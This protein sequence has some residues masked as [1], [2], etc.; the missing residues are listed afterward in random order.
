V[1]ELASPITLRS[2][3]R[4]PV[5]SRFRELCLANAALDALLMPE[6]EYRYFSFNRDW[7]AG[8][9]MASLRDGSGGHHF[10][11]FCESGTFVKGF[12]P[13]SPLSTP[14]LG[15][16]ADW[17]T[18]DVPKG[19]RAALAEPAFD[20]EALTYCFWSTAPSAPWCTGLPP[21]DSLLDI[22][23]GHLAILVDEPAVYADWASEYY[24]RS[25]SADTVR[26]FH[27]L[28]PM[29][30]QTLSRLMDVSR[31]EEFTDELIEIGY[32]VRERT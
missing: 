30:A 12:D 31:V 18:A 8:E 2:L 4:L 21:S 13:V 28:V 20:M 3:E 6:W 9:Q 10:V 26:L 23:L 24:E 22:P 14:F 1:P 17:R 5:A 16:R 32:P 27:Q 29:D 7:D 19:L 25:I 11:L 15:K